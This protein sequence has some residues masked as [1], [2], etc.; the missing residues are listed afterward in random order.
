[1]QVMYEQLGINRNIHQELVQ[2]NNI[3]PIGMEQPMK[4]RNLPAGRMGM[5]ISQQLFKRPAESQRKHLGIF[6]VPTFTGA[7]SFPMWE[8]ESL[9]TQD[10]GAPKE[11]ANG[12]DR[13]PIPTF[14]GAT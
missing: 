9:K 1:M 11:S 12:T 8:S 14:P 2:E 5:R 10:P 13:T 6:P 7:T 4:I 3:I